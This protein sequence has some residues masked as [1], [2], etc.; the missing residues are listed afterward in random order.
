MDWLNLVKDG[1]APKGVSEG[2]SR[3]ESPGEESAGG[4]GTKKV[5][6]SIAKGFQGIAPP[7]GI[8]FPA[9]LKGDVAKGPPGPASAKLESAM[10]LG[11]GLLKALEA[12]WE[13]CTVW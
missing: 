11:A 4:S 10:Q 2:T 6:Q 12:D 1:A 3:A 7:S 5:F 13:V 9:A 8:S